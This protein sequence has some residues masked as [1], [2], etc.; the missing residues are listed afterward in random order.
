M[1]CKSDIQYQSSDTKR[2]TEKLTE[3]E[4]QN[5]TERQR[6]TERQGW[7]QN[8]TKAPATY[9]LAIVSGENPKEDPCMMNKILFLKKT[10]KYHNSF[11]FRFSFLHILVK[12]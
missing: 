5:D 8:H 7:V 12:I 4:R 2:E 6:K 3:T 1:T 9:I 11:C 10:L